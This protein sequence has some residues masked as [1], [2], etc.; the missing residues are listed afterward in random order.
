MGSGVAEAN[1]VDLLHPYLC[2]PVP[3][4]LA[5]LDIPLWLVL[6]GDCAFVPTELLLKYVD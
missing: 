2:Q 4:A 5:P 6:L 1:Q 3:S